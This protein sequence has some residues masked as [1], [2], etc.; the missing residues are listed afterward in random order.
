MVKKGSC[1]LAVP[2]LLVCAIYGYSLLGIHVYNKVYYI[3]ILDKIRRQRCFEYSNPE[4]KKALKWYVSCSK[5]SIF[6]FT[7]ISHIFIHVHVHINIYQWRKWYIQW[8]LGKVLHVLHWDEAEGIGHFIF[9]S[10]IQTMLLG[11]KRAIW[12][13][14]GC[15]VFKFINTNL[16]FFLVQY[17]N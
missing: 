9:L 2:Y 3:V 1:Y 13:D 11:L 8:M 6:M 17:G 12:T 4:I 7:I 10:L 16:P 14:F 5:P 15:P